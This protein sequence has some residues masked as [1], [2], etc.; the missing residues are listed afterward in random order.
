[1]ATAPQLMCLPNFRIWIPTSFSLP[2]KREFRHICRNML[3]WVRLHW[4]IRLMSRMSYTQEIHMWFSY[5]LLPIILMRRLQ[6]KYVVITAI[7]QWFLSVMPMIMTFLL[8]LSNRHCPQ[9]MS[10]I[11]RLML[12]RNI[13][14]MKTRNIYYMHILPRK[15]MLPR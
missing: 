8:L 5:L 7:I 6:Q 3:R 14:L 2:Q 13:R 12:C 4:S 15:M 11:C 10:N 1:M 9:A